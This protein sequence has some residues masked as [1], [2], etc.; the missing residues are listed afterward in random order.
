[1]FHQMVVG[2]KTL[3]NTFKQG[4]Q[5]GKC[6]VSKQSLFMFDHQTFPVWTGLNIY[7]LTIFE[8]AA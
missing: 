6:L 4:V 2:V 3:S 8:L 1:M 7:H 5:K